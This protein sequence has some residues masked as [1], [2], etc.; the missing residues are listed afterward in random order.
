MNEALRTLLLHLRGMWN[1]RFFGLAAA[2][3]VAVVGVTVA[4]LIP[5]NYAASARAHVDTQSMLR[6][7][8]AGLSIQPNL[9]QQ[10]AMISR[11]LLSRPNIEKLAKLS[12]LAD[13]L[14]SPADFDALV[15]KLTKKIELTGNATSNIY[16]I[17]YRDSDPQKALSVIESLLEIFV[18]ASVGDERQDAKG[19][20][21][22]LDEQISQ[23][24]QSLQQAEGRLKD[25]RL[26]YLGVPGQNGQAGQDYFGR[27]S[28]LADDITNT[29]LEL[30]AAVESRESYKRDL[31]GQTPTLPSMGRGGNAGMPVPEIDTRIAAQKAKLDEL[32]RNYTD[33]HP[34]VVGTRRVLAELEVQQRHE[35]QARDLALAKLGR[36]AEPTESNPVYEKMRVSLA[37]AE[38]KAASLQGKL[39]AYEAEYAQLKVQARLVP[40]VEAELAQ[41]NRDY[42]IQK[43]TYSD[44]LARREAATMGVKVQDTEGAPFRVV[45]PPRVTSKPVQPTRLV[46]LAIAFALALGIGVFVSFIANELMPT[47]QD[48]RSLGAAVE[49]PVLGAVS[50]V[51]DEPARLKRRRRYQLFFGA[52]GGLFAAFAAVLAIAL[53]AVR[54]A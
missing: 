44:L 30:R 42:D 8:M 15:D 14:E 10:V 20:L 48:L 13:G 3:I 27:M 26:K 49:R 43:K 34:D 45:D 41:L 6:P 1:R 54:A 47:F 2:W 16:V 25:F 38:A 35:R 39:S 22:F 21:R 52:L 31:S 12:H 4:F 17:S 7:V 46:M 50:M 5:E 9:D 37:D 24:E 11:T 32:L 23:Y 51:F 29:K 40:Q 36:S 28:K 18:Q 33:E 53:L 19:A